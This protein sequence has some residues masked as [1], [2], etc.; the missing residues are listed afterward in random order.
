MIYER[1]PLRWIDSFGGPLLLLSSEYFSVWQGVLT[2]FDRYGYNWPYPD[3]P[4][5]PEETDY[6]RACAIQGYIGLVNVGDGQGVVLGDAPMSTAWWPLSATEGLL[7]RWV[8]GGDAVG[9]LQRLLPIDE[10]TWESTGTLFQISQ[11][12][13]YLF[14][15]SAAGEEETE[16][17][18]ITLAAGEFAIDTAIARP[19]EHTEMVVHR[20]RR[21]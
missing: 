1:G 7:I 3:E 11:N 10:R 2:D 12:P 14:D 8:Y 19:D 9:L 13:L 21:P 20:L 6:D 17:L 15:S 16:R 18:T 5:P 4:S